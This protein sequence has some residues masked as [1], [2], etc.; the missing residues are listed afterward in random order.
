MTPLRIAYIVAHRVRLFFRRAFQIKT[1][2]VKAVVLRGREV[3]LIRHSYFATDRFMLPGGGVGRK[4]TVL[5]AGIREAL[6][7]TG[8]RLDNV[9][10]HGDFVSNSEGFPDHITVIVGETRDDPMPDAGELLEA[11]FFPLDALPDALTDAS[12]RR[13]IE[14]R[15]GLPPSGEW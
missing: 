11:R 1:R 15:D 10:V 14:I 8:C 4:E 2:G 6:E 5:A 9:Y 12:R 13:I 3:L 7:E